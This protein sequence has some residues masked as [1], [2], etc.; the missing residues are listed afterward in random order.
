MGLFLTDTDWVYD[1]SREGSY[2]LLAWTGGSGTLY[3]KNEADGSEM[4]IPYS[5]NAFG[6][7]KGADLG[8]AASLVQTSSAGGGVQICE[9]SPNG[10]FGLGTFPCHGYLATMGG[11]AGT[12]DTSQA[13]VL[14]V[15]GLDIEAI[16]LSW[17][18]FAAM[19]PGVG[20][21]IALASFGA[22]TTPD[23]SPTPDPTD[24]NTTVASNDSGGGGDSGGGDG[25]SATA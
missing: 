9:F 5:Y 15:F 20:A 22:A 25:G 3:L 17:G 8:A 4:A 2:S 13:V 7:S 12:Q 24:P 14:W 21:S 16:L 23:G 10:D 11:N 6:E 18:Q 1:T 19:F